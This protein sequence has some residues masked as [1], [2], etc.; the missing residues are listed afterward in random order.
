[1]SGGFL[2]DDSD[3]LDDQRGCLSRFLDDDLDQQQLDMMG[4]TEQYF[5][6]T[7]WYDRIS[8]IRRIYL[9]LDARGFLTR[10]LF[11]SD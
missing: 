10:H 3:D 4:V 2:F 8:F 7:P 11:P 5:P 6:H 9:F 1:M